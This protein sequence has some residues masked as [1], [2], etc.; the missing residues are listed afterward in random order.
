VVFFCAYLYALLIT[1]RGIFRA[2]LGSA[3]TVFNYFGIGTN[4]A[5]NLLQG[6]KARNRIAAGIGY[7]RELDGL[8]KQERRR[9]GSMV[10]V[11]WMLWLVLAAA[12]TVMFVGGLMTMITVV[13]FGF[14]S[15]GMTFMGLMGVLPVVVSHPAPEKAEPEPRKE[16]VVRGRRLHYPARSAHA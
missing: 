13:V 6:G 2:D 1:D 4:I 14:I 5:P 8:I 3:H 9:T 12:A 7:R 15:F 11:Y 10:K 16:R